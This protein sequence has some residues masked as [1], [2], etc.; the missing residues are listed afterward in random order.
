MLPIQ[1]LQFILED[2]KSHGITNVGDLSQKYNVSE[3][4]IR[5]DLK[6]LEDQGLI[7]RTHG[8]AVPNSRALDEPR[9]VQKQGVHE[10]EK[11]QIARYAVE[12]FVAEHDIISMEGGTT[13]AGM[14]MFMQ[15]TRNITVM[16][17]GLHTLFEL[18]RIAAGNTIISTGGILREVSNTL[19]GPVAERHFDEFN[20]AKVFLSATGWTAANGFTDPNMLETQ[21]KQAMIKS[22]GKVIM[23]MD[24]S[25]F[26]IVSL[27]SF[28]DAYAVDA[29][30]TNRNID[31]DVKRL[32]DEQEV[33]VHIAT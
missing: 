15:H 29:L 3:M 7:T 21:V 12:H 30:I 13:V 23:L 6:Q 4:T 18:Q 22:A 1:R 31:D 24:S 19:V 26:G 5:R 33:T 11:R 16:T 17:N 2:I 25:K 28:L 32:F 14:V 10:A 20:A 27:K 8:G 9:F